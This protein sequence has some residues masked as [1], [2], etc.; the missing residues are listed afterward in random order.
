MNWTAIEDGLPPCEESIDADP[1]TGICSVPP[2]QEGFIS[3]KC[4]AWT[5]YCEF[6]VAYLLDQRGKKTWQEFDDGAN[7]EGVTHWAVLTEPKDSPSVA[8]KRAEAR[9]A[10][11]AEI[12]IDQHIAPT[13]AGNNWKN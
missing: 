11:M 9:A 13:N 2:E 6:V 7:L 3:G 10:L 12:E 8:A 1:K 4:V 5:L